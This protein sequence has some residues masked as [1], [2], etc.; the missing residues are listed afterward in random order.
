MKRFGLW[1]ILLSVKLQVQ[2]T[3]YACN[4]PLGI[5]KIEHLLSQKFLKNVDAMEN[6]KTVAQITLSSSSEV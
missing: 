1:E 3:C 2:S 6:R 4:Y 5:H